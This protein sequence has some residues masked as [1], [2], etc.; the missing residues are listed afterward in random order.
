MRQFL[1]LSVAGCLL[2][3][4]AIAPSCKKRDDGYTQAL[5]IRSNDLTPS[6]CGYLLRFTNG[7]LVKPVYV[8]SAFQYDSLPVLVKY[9]NTGKESNCMPQNPVQIISL[10]DI[11]RE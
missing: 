3:A 9:T 2:L 8:P 5:V 11:R 4:F 7:Q 1:Y 10:D 6:G